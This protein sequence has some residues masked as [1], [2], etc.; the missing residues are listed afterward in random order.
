MTAQFSF[1]MQAG[2]GPPLMLSRQGYLEPVELRSRVSKVGY[3]DSKRASRGYEVD[4]L[5]QKSFQ[6]G[7]S[8]AMRVALALTVCPVQWTDAHIFVILTLEP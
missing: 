1:K 4:F 6:V 7:R 3:G 2:T 5:S 8:C